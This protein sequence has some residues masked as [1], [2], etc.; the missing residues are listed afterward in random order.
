MKTPGPDSKEVQI[1]V[2]FKAV[3][4]DTRQWWWD[5]T[6]LQNVKAYEAIIAEWRATD[7]ARYKKKRRPVAQ[8]PKSWN[9]RRM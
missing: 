8:L 4:T 6:V 3:E 1:I 2:S 7:G 5:V 9:F